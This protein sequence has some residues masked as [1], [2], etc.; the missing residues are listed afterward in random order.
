[1]WKIY[2]KPSFFCILINLWFIICWY[3]N[4]GQGKDMY[5]IEGKCKATQF[6]DIQSVFEQ[7]VLLKDVILLT[8]M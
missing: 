7:N 5:V 3:E 6:S 1:M 4:I 2:I 8:E